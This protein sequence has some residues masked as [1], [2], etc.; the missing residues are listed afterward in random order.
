MVQRGRRQPKTAMTA[1]A[2]VVFVGL[3]WW[4]G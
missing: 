3:A 4:R 2:L 1:L